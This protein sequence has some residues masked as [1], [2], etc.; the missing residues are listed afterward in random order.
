M[1]R[2]ISCSQ[3]GGAIADELAEATGGPGKKKALWTR[4]LLFAEEPQ[5]RKDVTVPI[6][7]L[8][9]RMIF[10]SWGGVIKQIVGFAGSEPTSFRGFLGGPVVPSSLLFGSRF[11]FKVTSQ[12]MIPLLQIRLLGYLGSVLLSLD[13]VVW[14][15]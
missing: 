7:P 6:L 10:I 4:L 1:V 11:P 15:L 14:E 8:Q 12:K 2:L 5:K 13:W 3:I 9:G